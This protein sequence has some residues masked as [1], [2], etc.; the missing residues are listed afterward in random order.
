[1][2]GAEGHSREQLSSLYPRNLFASDVMSVAPP[3]ADHIGG[4]VAYRYMEDDGSL[5]YGGKCV[6]HVEFSATSFPSNVTWYEG[7][8]PDGSNAQLQLTK[9]TWAYDGINLQSSEYTINPLTKDVNGSFYLFAAE[10]RARQ[11][12]INNGFDP[13]LPSED[14]DGTWP[15][16]SV[17]RGETS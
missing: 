4:P 8:L 16:A 3:L 14:G 12:Q 15:W 10:F 13:R 11:G 1:D 5:F 7:W 6:Y 2:G 17:G 9:R